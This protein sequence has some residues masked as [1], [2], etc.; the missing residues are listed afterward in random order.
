MSKDKAVP[1]SKFS[2]A[3][4]F[5]SLA[6]RVASNVAYGGLKSMV[7]GQNKSTKELVLNS[8]NIEQLAQQLAHLRGA[9]MKLGQLLSMDAGELLSPE[10][11][12]LL[13]RLRNKAT[14]M[15]HKQLTQTLKQQ[16][17]A[18]WLDGLANFELRPF[19]A[20]SIGQVHR[21]YTDSGT[22]LAVKVQYPGVA[23][24]IES[25]VDN[26]V[27]LLKLTGLLPNGLDIDELI[28]EAKA[29][30]LNEA[31]YTLE[32]H[33]MS[34][35]Q[36]KLGP[37]SHFVVPKAQSELCTTQILA[38]E[39]V[40]GEAIEQALS[41]TQ[42]ERNRLVIH[43]LTLFM[44]E[45]FD[46]RLMQTDPNFA[47]Y[48]YQRDTGRIVLLDFGA[49]R[50]ISEPISRGYWQLIQGAITGERGVMA[51]AAR[52]IGYFSDD[53]DKAYEHNV[54]DIFALACEPLT[55]D[56][57]Y[58]FASSDL[59]ARIKQKGLAMSSREQQWHSP[60]VDALFIHRKL[61]GLFLIAAKL[62]AKVNVSDIFNEQRKS[63]GVS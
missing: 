7:T 27:R 49:T 13:S 35:Y 42:E 2:R 51:Q 19:A 58:D 61:A 21:A 6:G 54:L 50:V 18:H 40:E 62:Q 47:N 57:E 12:A 26:V 48:L 28:A 22:K 9:A 36:E 60:P 30:L 37:S 38:M 5:G 46:F 14:P 20:A 25:D 29:Q 15:P 55:A 45:L 39:F 23:K 10:L 41:C 43:L 34:Q 56:G 53:V 24:S 16:W 32:A 52:D 3:L 17:G 33:Y 8:K 31:D 11:S 59:A 4:R 44:L 1:T 63:S